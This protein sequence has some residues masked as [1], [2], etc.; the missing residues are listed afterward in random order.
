M[1]YYPSCVELK[2]QKIIKLKFIRKRL[3]MVMG[4]RLKIILNF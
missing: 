2:I 1:T 3:T 4:K